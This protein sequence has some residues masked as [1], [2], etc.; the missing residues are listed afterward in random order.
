MRSGHYAKVNNLNIYYEIHGE[1]KPLLLLHGGFGLVDMFD[2]LIPVLKPNHTV[3][4]VELQGHGRTADADRPLTFE[5]MADDIACLIEQLRYENADL[6]GYSLGGGV[7]WQTAIRHPEIVHK[8]VTISAPIK[9]DGWYPE[10]L[11]GIASVS[12][13]GMSGTW[14]YDAYANIA[15]N[16]EDWFA[17]VTK[18]R[19]LLI[20][21]YDWSAEVTKMTT[22]TLIL[23]GDADS[24]RTAHAV[25]IFELL[26]GGQADGAS[27]GMPKSQLA[28]LPGTN[29]FTIIERIDLLQNM[30]APFL[31]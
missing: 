29:H 1:G 15:P 18:T 25:E 28:I 22:P 12:V 10:V 8:L 16:P 7:A 6:L 26:G 11:A 14:L 27:K 3:I 9:R 19:Q 17:L 24:V 13:E 4:P 30:I 31:D 20:Q 23:I 2:N 21:D 5:G